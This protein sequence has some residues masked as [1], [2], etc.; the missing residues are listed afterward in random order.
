MYG[1]LLRRPDGLNVPR[2]KVSSAVGAISGPGFKA[3]PMRIKSLK[4]IRM[5]KGIHKPRVHRRDVVQ[6]T[7]ASPVKAKCFICKSGLRAPKKRWQRET[8]TPTNQIHQFGCPC[9]AS[10]SIVSSLG[11]LES[12]PRICCIW[13]LNI[14]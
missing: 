2:T 1:S 3:S 5:A 9:P 11:R 7:A 14:A 4:K 13:S 8:P 6:R 12:S 10:H